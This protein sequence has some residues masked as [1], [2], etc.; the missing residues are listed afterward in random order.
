MISAQLKSC[1]VALRGGAEKGSLCQSGSES[2]GGK[3]GR[4]RKAP[5]VL[6]IDLSVGKDE[7]EL[8]R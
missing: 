8:A 3:E 4:S 6:D 2:E 1:V 5:G 7:Y